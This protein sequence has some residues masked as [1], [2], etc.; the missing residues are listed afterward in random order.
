MYRQVLT[1]EGLTAF[2]DGSYGFGRPGTEELQLLQYKTRSLLVQTGLS[3]PLIRQRERNLT[4]TGLI[5]GSNDSA[6]IFDLPDTP[7][8]TKDRLRGVRVK[9]EGDFA[10]R[11]NGIN[12][13]SLIFSRG[14]TGL[15][16][17]A[18]YADLASR[19]NGRVDFS[20]VEALVSRLQPLGAG[21]S[22]LGVAYGQYAFT[23]LL[24]S[25]LCGYGGRLFGRAFD[26]S[27]FV[28]DS[29]FEAL[30]E[31]R[32]DVPVVIKDLTLNQLYGFADHGSLHNIAP[33][34]GTFTNVD[35]GSVGAGLRLGWL[36]YVTA[37]FSVAHIVQGRN[38]T[39]TSALPGQPFTGQK[40]TRYFFILS[41]KL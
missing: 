37:D 25:E 20:K 31:L 29:C 26:P 41:G 32:Y 2:I 15:G 24:V 30:G 10:D 36:D 34:A 11:F 7:P 6:S 21:F 22:V 5:F 3:Y 13:A 39:G 18:N 40:S 38:L 14:F 9:A 35:A 19:A 33:V 8:S 4:L 16:S 28:G 1:P 12:Q 17:T 23:P 27:Q